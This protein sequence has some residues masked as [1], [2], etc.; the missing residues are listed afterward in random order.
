MIETVLA[1]GSGAFPA[2]SAAQEVG[3]HRVTCACEVENISYAKLRYRPVVL[4]DVEAL[5][6]LHHVCSHRVHF[7]RRGLGALTRR[8]YVASHRVAICSR[9]IFVHSDAYMWQQCEESSHLRLVSSTSPSSHR[10]R[11]SLFLWCSVGC[12]SHWPPLW[13]KRS[14]KLALTLKRI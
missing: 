13:L 12:A 14:H 3:H 7:T 11:A 1:H 6:V 8:E 9:D 2:T 10:R 4:M 5:R